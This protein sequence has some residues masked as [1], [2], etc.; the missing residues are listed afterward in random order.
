MR[1]W[2]F[3]CSVWDGH[4]FCGLQEGAGGEVVERSQSSGGVLVTDVL[5]VLPKKA[6]YHPHDEY[7]H[8]EGVNIL[9]ARSLR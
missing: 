6:A 7:E 8:S 9:E 3:Q 2:I 5:A 4:C 1:K